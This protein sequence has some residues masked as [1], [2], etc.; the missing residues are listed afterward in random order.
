VQN[1]LLRRCDEQLR[2]S[3]FAHAVVTRTADRVRKIAPTAVVCGE[4]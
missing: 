4:V 2:Q 1:R 3:D